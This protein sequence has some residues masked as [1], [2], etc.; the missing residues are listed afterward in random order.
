[1]KH[2]INAPY[3]TTSSEVVRPPSARGAIRDIALSLLAMIRRKPS[4]SFLRCLYCH[5][6]FDDQLEQFSQVIELLKKCGT[7]VNTDTCVQMLQGKKAI[8][9]RYFHLSFDDGFRNNFTNALPVL[10]KHGVPAIFFVPTSLVSADRTTAQR[11]CSETTRY[12]ATIEMIRWEELAETISQGFEIGSHTRTHCR[13]SSISVGSQVMREEIHGSKSD[14]EK[15]L[16]VEC[17]YISWP[18]GTLDDVDNS[19][20]YAVRDAGYNACFGAFRGTIIP[21]KTNRFC[22]PRHHFE[23]EWPIQ[24]IQYFAEGNYEHA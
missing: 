9:G 19:S 13:L 10:K 24:H 3:A 11:Y 8:S 14:L 7:F 21:N 22:I 1:M 23:V 17:K 4:S 6:V 2:S 18:Y 15:N 20:L 16:G 5:Y 12:R